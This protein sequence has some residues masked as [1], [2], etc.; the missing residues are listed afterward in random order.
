[1]ISGPQ[2]LVAL[3]AAIDVT[4]V[5]GLGG[6]VTAHISAQNSLLNIISSLTSAINGQSAVQA[7]V[8]AILASGL[9]TGKIVGALA[10]IYSNARTFSIDVAQAIANRVSSGVIAADG[11]IAEVSV[12]TIIGQL[13]QAGGFQF[14]PLS[15]LIGNIG[16]ILGDSAT[17]LV[18]KVAQGD[19][20]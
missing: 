19:F 7:D 6:T 5:P 9:P 12:Y 20:D 13:Y 14:S 10:A 4:A 15:E 16:A 2:A 3:T 11:Q 8:N 17:T 1:G 18:A